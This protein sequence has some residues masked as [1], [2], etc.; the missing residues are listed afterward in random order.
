MSNEDI[1]AK[2]K[3][4]WEENLKLFP[5]TS[6]NY[7]DENLVRLFSGRYV[8]VPQPPAKVLDHGFGT[9]NSLVFLANKGYQCA[10]CEI[11][12]HFISQANALFQSLEM[13]VDLRPVTGL[14]I[15]FDDDTF[16]VVVSWNV[17]H[18]NGTREAVSQVIEELRRVLKPG[19]VLLLSTIHPDNYL[20]SRMRHLGDGSYY[21]ERESQY[22]NR[23]GLT[24]FCTQSPEELSGLCRGFSSVKIGSAA[25]DLFNPDRRAAWFLV[26][27]IK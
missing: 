8:P 17:I 16:D 23:Q 4:A 3:L 7:P 5:G 27:A 10:G 14:E 20:F 19:G 21:I 12:E 1:F 6:L 13:P 9:A 15:P 22:D 2:S 25:C 18:Y 11:S 26:Y 24:F